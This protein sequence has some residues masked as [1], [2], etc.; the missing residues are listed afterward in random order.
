MSQQRLLAAALCIT[1]PVTAMARTGGS[2][3]TVKVAPTKAT[4]ASQL[5]NANA[6]QNL[7]LTIRGG[8]GQ[9]AFRFVCNGAHCS[10]RHTHPPGHAHTPQSVDIDVSISGLSLQR[11]QLSASR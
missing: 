3:P 9:W 5:N 4:A 2:V 10:F 1:A 7:H 11:Q 6:A 8:T